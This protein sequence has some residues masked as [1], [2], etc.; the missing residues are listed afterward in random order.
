VVLDAS[1]AGAQ[2]STLARRI[3]AGGRAGTLI[4]VCEHVEEAAFADEGIA[5]V[6]VRPLDLDFVQVAVM[7]ACTAAVEAARGR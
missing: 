4:V 1:A 3:L 2:T 5:H 6:L 7:S